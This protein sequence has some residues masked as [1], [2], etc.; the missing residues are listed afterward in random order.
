MSISLPNGNHKLP[1]ST[2]SFNLPPVLTCPGSTKE[3][4]K[5]CYAKKA[6]VQYPNVRKAWKDNF[7]ESKKDTFVSEMIKI[8]GR[9]R[10]T[11]TVR[12][13]TSGDFY[14]QEYFDKWVK[15]AEAFPDLVF[16]AYTKVVTL[17][18]DR[19]PSNFIVLLSDDHLIFKNYHFKFNGVATVTKRGNTPDPEAFVCPGDCR[20]C[21]Y[22]YSGGKKYVTFEEH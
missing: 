1:R 10:K 6:W 7:E 17:D 21:N 2:V 12:I 13:H 19:R 4:R 3:C 9:K 16:Y 15:I 22:C 14:S 20:S 18:V 8:L 5:H 11:T